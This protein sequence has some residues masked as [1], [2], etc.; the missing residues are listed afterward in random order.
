MKPRLAPLLVSLPVAAALVACS[1][2][3]PAASSPE[4]KGPPPPPAASPSLAPV[5]PPS[6]TVP[7][8]S[9]SPDQG[10]VNGPG[11]PDLSIE[12][13]GAQA[14]RVTIAD[15][16]AK[17]W[18]LVVAGTGS[19][20]GDR[21]VL[22]VETGDVAPAITTLDTRAGVDGD[23]QAQPGLEQGETAGRVC[24]SVLPVC[25]AASSVRL[26]ENGDGTLEVV[27]TRTDASVPLG[28]SAATAGWPAEP[29]ILGPW[30]ATEVFPW[31][32]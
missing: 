23:P 32:A 1:A 6:A 3:A 7:V 29:F 16:S 9:S 14:L 12:P 31:Q 22:E 17:A 11:T 10:N 24:S 13:V 26:P 19:R 15:R 21:W 20:A 25:V 28:V 2:G 8:A 5:A 27:L 30:T 4:A 18:R